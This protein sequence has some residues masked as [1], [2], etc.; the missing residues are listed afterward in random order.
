[1]TFE[2][3]GPV[4]EGTAKAVE[5]AP[6]RNRTVIRPAPRWG[7]LDVR[8]LWAYRELLYL[9]T[10][11]DIK[12][13]YKQTF[14]GGSWAV[15]QPLLLMVVFTVFLGTFA[16]VPSGGVPYP[17][18]AYSGLVP[19]TLFSASL[20][21]ASESLVRSGSLVEKIYFPRILMPLAAAGSYVL[22]FLIASTLLVG[23][24]IYYGKI[25]PLQAV[26]LPAFAALALLSALAFGIWLAALNVRYRD[27][28][29]AMPFLVQ[30][31]LFA[32][33]VAYPISVVPERWWALYGLNPMAGVIGGFRWALLGNGDRPGTMIAVSLAVIVLVLVCGVVYF[34]KS[35]RSFADVI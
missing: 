21:A 32:S 3:H 28:R 11:R 13:R 24:M 9:L 2:R 7:S 17:L 31:W 14:F 8:E 15:V 18:L 29:V 6:L 27:V 23:L 4:M 5:A 19:W 34:Q 10:W 12:S 16:K 30:L 35:E 20:I 1:M 22:D 26:W 33:P 25:P